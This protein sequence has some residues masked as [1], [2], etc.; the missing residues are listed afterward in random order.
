MFFNNTTSKM[1]LFFCFAPLSFMYTQV[2][3]VQCKM[4]MPIMVSTCHFQVLI[5]NSIKLHLFN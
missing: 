1:K 2:K 5:N 3:D 4:W